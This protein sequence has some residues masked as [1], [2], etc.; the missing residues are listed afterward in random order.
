MAKV[1]EC[2][3]EVRGYELDGYAHVNHAVYV[4]YLE[5]ARWSMLKSEGITIDQFKQW[6]RWPVIA[7][8]QVRYRKPCFAGE[9][10]IVHS[11]ITKDSRVQFEV[12]Q[13]IFRAGTLVL[14]ATV[15]IV[16]VNEE[17]RPA[18]LPPEIS[19]L[20]INNTNAPAE[21]DAK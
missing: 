11:H 19:R 4:S 21:G 17:G 13:K 1:Y 10:L 2:P 18:S 12:E 16:I 8:I 15:G 20:W 5:H 3:I 6:K 7:E 14:E 9:L